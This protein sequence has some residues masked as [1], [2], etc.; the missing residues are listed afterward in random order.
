MVC[1]DLLPF[2]WYWNVGYSNANKAVSPMPKRKGLLSESDIRI[3]AARDHGKHRGGRGGDPS[4]GNPF[5]LRK[6]DIRGAAV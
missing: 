3:A 6:S 4:K 2:N 1:R 5:F